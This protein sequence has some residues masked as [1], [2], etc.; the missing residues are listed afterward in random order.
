MVYSLKFNHVLNEILTMTQQAERTHT[1][2]GTYLKYKG[3][4]IEIEGDD[5]PDSAPTYV[6]NISRDGNFVCNR[7][8]MESALDWI[9]Q[10]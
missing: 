5:P 2:D 8:H 7:P 3:Y 1:F 10:Q 9:D 6:L 4:E